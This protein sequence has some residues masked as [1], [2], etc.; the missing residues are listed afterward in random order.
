[1]SSRGETLRH[2]LSLMEVPLL[3]LS[4]ERGRLVAHIASLCEEER[5]EALNREAERWPGG[6]EHLRAWV[7]QFVE[8]QRD[9][10][11]TRYRLLRP[12]GAGGEALVYESEE[13]LAPEFPARR[14]ALK[15]LR[16]GDRAD[17]DARRRLV[18]EELVMK[19]LSNVDGVLS[20]LSSG[21]LSLR[22]GDTMLQVPYLTMRFIGSELG[23]LAAFESLLEEMRPEDLLAAM[24]SVCRTLGDV[25]EQGIVHGDLSARNTLYSNRKAW[26]IDLKDVDSEDPRSG[27][28][29][30]G[31]YRPPRAG[32]PNRKDDMRAVAVLLCEAA[33]GKIRFDSVLHSRDGE[34]ASGLLSSEARHRRCWALSVVRIRQLE[35]SLRAICRRCLDGEYGSPGKVAD[36]V[37]V[38]LEREYPFLRIRPLLVGFGAWELAAHVGLAGLFRY[39]EGAAIPITWGSPGA[40]LAV[41]AAT[42]VATIVVYAP[43]L[44]LASSMISDDD[45]P[46]L[47]SI[48]RRKY[49]TSRLEHYKALPGQLL[50]VFERRARSLETHVEGTRKATLATWTAQCVAGLIAI[51]VFVLAHATRNATTAGVVEGVRAAYI[52]H[53]FLCAIALVE[54]G[55]QLSRPVFLTLG[56]VWAVSSWFIV[57]HMGGSEPD[58]WP[59]ERLC[60]EPVLFGVL[61]LV[62]AVT[63]FA[64]TAPTRSLI[65]GE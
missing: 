6:R 45:L 16:P 38:F 9:L 7:Q 48:L 37:E 19:R 63:V 26:V 57:R 13:V 22:C 30:A 53:L 3:S 12:I 56:G 34:S 31:Y 62:S 49:W 14:V 10:E 54:M 52:V 47:G 15:I 21:E 59:F 23:P 20:P 44:D 32:P 41:T 27:P 18:D 36:E 5:D 60:W 17:P 40:G 11:S 8:D 25:H 43:M 33:T 51:L 1:M 29:T 28:R 39:A 55:L 61:A 2:L 64:C 58:C 50:K 65:K 35:G 24:V 4:V 46:R 42:A